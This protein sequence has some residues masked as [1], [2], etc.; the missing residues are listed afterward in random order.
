MS[1][2]QLQGGRGNHEIGTE[3]TA[4]DLFA[5]GTV[6]DHLPGRSVGSLLFVSSGSCLVLNVAIERD[7]TFPAH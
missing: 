7:F 2:L 5:I 1:I 6:A 4:A 3:Y